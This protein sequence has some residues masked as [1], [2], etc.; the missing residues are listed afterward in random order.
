MPN[1]NKKILIS[2]T[3]S[4]LGKYL[5]KKLHGTK[6]NRNKNI[7]YYKK[8][9]WDLIIHS[10]FYS[11]KDKKKYIENIKHTSL[12]SE[13]NYKKMIF[14]SSIAVYEGTRGKRDERKKIY[15]NKKHNSYAKSKLVCEKIVLKKKQ[16][17]I[18][19]GSIIGKEMRKNN[20]YKLKNYKKP[21]LTI[22]KKSVYSFVTYDE[23]IK[24][25]KISIKKNL[26]GIYN[27]LRTDYMCIGKINEKYNKN[28]SYGKYIFKC[29]KASNDKIQKVI[30][31]NRKSSKEVFL[32]YK[33][34]RF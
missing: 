23:I 5:Y 18:R 1:I 17:I 34:D 28:I 4:G 12:L 32:Q 6:Y 2:G 26:F 22:S 33:N 24:F 3:S 25:I 13:L 7:S 20:I 16:L 11:G 31:L 29:T 15:F 19:L 30:D 27:F 9:F 8:T 21:K 10:G 14:I